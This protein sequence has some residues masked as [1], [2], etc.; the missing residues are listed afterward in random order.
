MRKLL[1]GLGIPY[2]GV[3]G[4]LPWAASINRFVLGVPFIYVWI[5]A[6]FFLTFCCL[7]ACWCVFDRKAALAAARAH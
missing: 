3:I 4:L 6:W 7:A 1:V 2:T 5:C